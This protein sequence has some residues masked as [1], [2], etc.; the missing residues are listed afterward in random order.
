MDKLSINPLG[1]FGANWYF[2]LEGVEDSYKFARADDMDAFLW[3]VIHKGKFPNSSAISKL[4]DIGDTLYGN[5]LTSVLPSDGTLLSTLEAMYDT[6][7]PSSI[8]LGNTFAYEGRT[9]HI[10]VYR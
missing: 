7:N 9:Y 8:L 2:G 1:E 4:S 10:N 3:F 6:S 5:R